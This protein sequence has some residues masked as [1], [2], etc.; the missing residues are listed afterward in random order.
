MHPRVRE[1]VR[2]LLDRQL[3]SG[4][5]NYGNTWVLG[6][7]LRPHQ[8]PTGVAMLAL[9]GEQDAE[10]RIAD[11]LAYLSRGLSPRT[12]TMTLAWALLGLAAHRRT[13]DNAAALLENA[14]QRLRQRGP[15]L[16]KTALL[17]LAARA[18]ESPLVRSA[19]TEPTHVRGASS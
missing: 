14:W 13:P 15:S 18:D 3:Y 2:L 16:W 19:R 9:A 11:S 17:L 4:G 6:R 7:P 8:A 12:T 1:A 5:C 10:G